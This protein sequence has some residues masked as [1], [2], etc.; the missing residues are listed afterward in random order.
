LSQEREADYR[1]T[2]LTALQEAESALIQFEFTGGELEQAASTARRREA[3]E[4]NARRELTAGRISRIPMADA[5]R[6][7]LEA[8]ESFV[9]AQ[10]S[11]LQSYVLLRRVLADAA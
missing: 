3:D 10:R 9:R 8:R 1:K 7:T 4:R 11:H 2:V 5:E 6:A